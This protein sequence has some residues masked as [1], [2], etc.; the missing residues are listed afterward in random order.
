M[1]RKRFRIPCFWAVRLESFSL[2][3]KKNKSSGH[4]FWAAD[5]RGLARIPV[6]WP[7]TSPASAWHPPLP[8]WA[9]SCWLCPSLLLLFLQLSCWGIPFPSVRRTTVHLLVVLRLRFHSNLSRTLNPKI[10]E[11]EKHWIYH[12]SS[13]S[14]VC[15]QITQRAC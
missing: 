7:I 13:P 1:W 3:Y 8:T 11:V 10:A 15:I 6:I 5:V 14:S 2:S 12:S 9:F 4:T